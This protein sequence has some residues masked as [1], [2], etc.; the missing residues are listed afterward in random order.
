VLRKSTG[1]GGCEA[2]T[3][4]AW[5]VGLRHERS[6]VAGAESFHSLEGNMCGTVTRGAVALPG[7]KATSRVAARACW[8]G[9]GQERG[10]ALR[11]PAV[12][13]ATEAAVRAPLAG[14]K[15]ICSTARD[16]G[17]GVA[18]QRIAAEMRA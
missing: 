10:N 16:V 12:A 6:Y 8:H 11:A 18:V 9:A 7:S 14:G 13:K 17:I 2:Y 4:I 5:G 3:A 15:G 1:D